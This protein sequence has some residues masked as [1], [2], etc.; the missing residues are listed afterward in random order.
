MKNFDDLKKKSNLE[1]SLLVDGNDSRKEARELLADLGVESIDVVN[2]SKK[3]RDFA[4]SKGI[5]RTPILDTINEDKE[6]DY[7]DDDA[8]FF[9]NKVNTTV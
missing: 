5:Y 9:D 2:K 7:V 8:E 4:K 1:V 3:K 6:D